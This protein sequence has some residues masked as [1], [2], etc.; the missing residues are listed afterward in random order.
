[1]RCSV[2]CILTVSVLLAC[3]M[4]S[5]FTGIESTPKISEKDLS[6]ERIV[7][8]NEEKFLSDIQPGPFKNWRKGK[9][10][11]VTDSRIN[12]ALEPTQN[13]IPANGD[14]LTYDRYR[15]IPS[16]TGTLNTE[17]VLVDQHG[18][19]FSHRINATPEELA[20]REKIEIPFTIDMSVVDSTK[21]KLINKTLFLRTSMW[22]DAD[23]NAMTGLKYIPVEIVD[24]E[25]GNT[26][27]PVKVKFKTINYPDIQPAYVFMSVGD[28][29]KSARNFASL[30]YFDDPRKRYPN[31]SDE[32]WASIIHSR[33]AP[34]MT[35]EECRLALGN[36]TSI[37]RRHGTNTYSERWNYENGISL[38]FDD[39]ILRNFRK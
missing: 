24:V 10:F 16:L 5:C 11:F 35:R 33:V 14:Y 22:F 13:P 39:G 37:D 9:I 26:V 4:S 29:A 25:P 15:E 27:Y 34:Y 30:F 1:M 2:H 3:G 18:N 19:E 17:I 23:G 21:E 36:P 20:S 28:S 8:T 32:N 12:L 38:I 7:V 6:R 31:I